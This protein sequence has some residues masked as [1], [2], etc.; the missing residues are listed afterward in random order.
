MTCNKGY[1]ETKSSK[2]IT[3]EKNI[4][5]CDNG[6]GSEGDE[7]G[8]SGEKKCASCNA[9]F[10]LSGNECIQLTCKCDNG[11]PGTDCAVKDGA[12]CATCHAN[13]KKSGNKCEPKTCK[14]DNGLPVGNGDCDNELDQRCQS[15]GCNGGYKYNAGT[16]SCDLVTI[17]DYC[18]VE[19]PDKK[20]FVYFAIDVAEKETR[21]KSMLCTEELVG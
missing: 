20:V 7:C 2:K 21:M 5:V 17:S 14:C 16:K 8:T 12:S 3:C 4:C 1:S 11:T 15:V 9:G 13:Y 19:V 6:K 18:E 10:D